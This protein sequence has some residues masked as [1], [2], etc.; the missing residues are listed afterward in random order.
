MARP[1][2][3]HPLT[4]C[5]MAAFLRRKFSQ[6]K[7]GKRGVWML[8][9]PLTTGVLDGPRLKPKNRPKRQLKTG[10]IH[11]LNQESVDFKRNE[12]CP[13]CF[14]PEEE[15]TLRHFIGNTCVYPTISLKQKKKNQKNMV[16]AKRPTVT[17]P[18]DVVTHATSRTYL[19][20]C[21]L[22]CAEGP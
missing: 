12:D 8:A 2:R 20:F 4:R 10:L 7:H 1:V 16:A 22:S 15:Q 13:V 11:E 9:A 18:L 19:H 5:R 6:S 17:S 21:W 3:I 14:W